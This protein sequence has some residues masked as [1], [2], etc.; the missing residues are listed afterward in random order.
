M[1]DLYI[2]LFLLSID[3]KLLLCIKNNKMKSVYLTLNQTVKNISSVHEY[4]LNFIVTWMLMK[5][6]LLKINHKS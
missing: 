2:F 3:H 1:E 6:D 4:I 5:G